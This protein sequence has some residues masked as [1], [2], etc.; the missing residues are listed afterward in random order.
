VCIEEAAMAL[1]QTIKQAQ[2]KALKKNAKIMAKLK[3]GYNP[4]HPLKQNRDYIL[5]EK[6]YYKAYLE[7]KAK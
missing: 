5:W 6:T 7:R 4:F 1:S 2:K 3:K